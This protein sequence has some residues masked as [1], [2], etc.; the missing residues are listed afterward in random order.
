MASLRDGIDQDNE[1][2]RKL[3]KKLGFKKKKNATARCF[4]EFGLSD[5]WSII[6][7]VEKKEPE[8]KG[9]EDRSKKRKKFQ[10]EPVEEDD[11]SEEDEEKM[12]SDDGMDSMEE[13]ESQDEEKSEE[14]S[15]E[16]KEDIYGR[17]KDR[18]GNIIK[19]EK[20][21][22]KFETFSNEE[23][24]ERAMK[25]V[26]GLLNRLSSSNLM[27]ISSSIEEILKDY[28][29]FQVTLC[30]TKCINNQLIQEAFLTPQRLISEYAMLIAVLN[31]NVGDEIGGHIIHQ[32]IKQL[33]I[34]LNQ[35][36]D[37]KEDEESKIIDNLVA[38]LCYL[39]ATGIIDSNLIYDIMEKLTNRFNAKCIQVILTT[40]KMIGFI[41]R[42]GDPVKLK[43]MI[44]DIQ[45]HAAQYETQDK[46][47][48]FMLEALAAIKNNNVNKLNSL[49][50]DNPISSIDTTT[51]RT[52]IK[53][54]LRTKTSVSCIPGRYNEVIQGN[55]WWINGGL[56]LESSS[57][58]EIDKES[59]SSSTSKVTQS[60]PS[61]QE[62]QESDGK[63]S[64]PDLCEKLCSKLRLVTPLRK[65]ILKSL[66]NCEDYIECTHRL[67][68]VGGKQFSEVINVCLLVA[69][70]EKKFNPFYIYLF[71]QLTC[72]DRK[73]K[74]SL[75]YSLRDRLNEL[76]R[77]SSIEKSN[78]SKLIV[79]LLKLDA[80]PITVLKTFQFSDLS[81]ESV[82]LLKSILI[83]V[84]TSDESVTSKILSKMKPKDPFAIA[85]K[86]FISCFMDSRYK[87]KML[88]LKR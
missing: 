79:E 12:D 66:L 40:L 41:L 73:F 72:C 17:L 45:S 25:R 29:L 14:E 36:T 37:S 88:F 86:L 6:D 52:T 9:S 18:K 22:I 34:M 53:N 39:H 42:R 19:M 87:E 70:K 75:L 35:L 56:L 2:I 13:E 28:S 68:K 71:K 82:E 78:L 31:T 62:S 80:I 49:N 77:L 76:D 55:R 26:R 65:L 85:L 27:T 51:L 20:P 32:F 7:Q 5:V 38:F 30:L 83:P 57:K 1:T 15:N 81:E 46:R 47:I 61:T 3:E 23:I 60:T 63:S 74:L 58:S 21:K 10:K 24:D 16:L 69:L 48:V 67:V 11:F 84:F 4:D 54:G 50:E 33:D 59:Q 8:E 44:L 43:K 64:E